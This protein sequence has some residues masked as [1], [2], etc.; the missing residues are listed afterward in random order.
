MRQPEMKPLLVGFVNNKQSYRQTAV[1]S[2]PAES[3]R[4]RSPQHVAALS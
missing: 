2:A 4:R 1:S 3:Q